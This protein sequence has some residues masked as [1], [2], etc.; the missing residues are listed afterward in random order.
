MPRIHSN[1]YTTALTGDITN[2]ATTMTVSSVA[3]L[4]TIGGNNFCY[5]TLDNGVSKEIVKATS[6]SGTTITMVRAQEGTT[7][8]AFLTGSSVSLRPTADSVDRKLDKPLYTTTATAAGTTTLTSAS[9]DIQYFTGSTTQN[10]DLPVTST[11]Y[12]GKMYLIC[13]RSSGTVTVRSS[14]GNTVQTLTAGTQAYCICILTSGTTAA[15][16]DP[17][18]L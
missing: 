12:A 7:G 3:A 6:N 18:P 4:P 2:V 11:L 15:S 9:N 5:L 14:G 8:T 16:W 10:C 17:I 1:N 13:N